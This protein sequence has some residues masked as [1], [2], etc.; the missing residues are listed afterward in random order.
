MS[1]KHTWWSI[2]K[3]VYSITIYS[4]LNYDNKVFCDKFCKV[5]KVPRGFLFVSMYFGTVRDQ[6][7]YSN[8]KKLTRLHYRKTPRT[9]FLVSLVLFFVHCKG[10]LY[11]TLPHLCFLFYPTSPSPP[12]KS[13]KNSQSFMFHS[14]QYLS[15]DNQPTNQPTNPPIQPTNQP[16]Q[17]LL[18]FVKFR[19]SF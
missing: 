12:N 13:E 2:S 19:F 15:A 16:T 3:G 1:R 4:Q 7:C 17:L 5:L 9:S 14:G 11:P 10:C 6:H 18:L 8:K